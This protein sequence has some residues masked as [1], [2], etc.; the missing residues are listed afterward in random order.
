MPHSSAFTESRSAWAFLIA[1]LVACSP[2]RAGAVDV[3]DA[4]YKALPCRPTIACTADLVPPGVVELEI[5]YIYRRLGSRANQHSVPFLLK[6][7]LAEWAQIQF[8][9][10]GPTIASPPAPARFFDDLTLGLKLHLKDQSND[11]PSLS[12]SATASIPLGSQEGYLR[13]YDAFFI[14]YITKDIR[15]LHA[16]LNLGLNLWRLDTDLLAQPWIALALSVALPH[17]LGPMIELYYFRD[18]APIEPADAGTLI[19]LSYQPR[20]WVVFDVGVDIGLVTAT[21]A[22][23]AFV[24]ATIIPLDLWDTGVERRARIE[25]ET[26]LER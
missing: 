8:G 10:N 13:T 22:V 3:P 23:S 25:R 20:P 1:T 24:G 21:R 16:D 2:V 6:L 18:A 26:R 11:S 4:T 17:G 19:A 9:S 7:T 14:A 15:W 5:G 12:V